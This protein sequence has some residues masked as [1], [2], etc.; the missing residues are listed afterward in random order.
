MKQKTLEFLEAHQSERPSTF[1]EDAKWRQENEVWLKWSRSVAMSIVDYLQGNGLSPQE[2]F[3]KAKQSDIKASNKEQ[4]N[5]DAWAAFLEM[6]V[7]AAEAGI[8]EMTLEEI[9][10]E[11]QK[12]R[13]EI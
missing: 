2:V 5:K 4:I 11:I 8:Q 12:V 10:A 13:N 3:D 1:K 6:R 9:N 7:A